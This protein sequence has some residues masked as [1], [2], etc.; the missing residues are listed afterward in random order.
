MP[1][2]N[3]S[4]IS[5]QIAGASLES[6]RMQTPH[7]E[8]ENIMNVQAIGAVWAHGK[9]NMLWRN[10]GQLL[11]I[12]WHCGKPYHAAESWTF[13]WSARPKITGPQLSLH[14]ADGVTIDH[15]LKSFH[16]G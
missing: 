5:F 7:A 16:C 2:R 10:G 15:R 12:S 1:P 3:F 9:S 8:G 11:F 4:L 13:V 14:H 6:S